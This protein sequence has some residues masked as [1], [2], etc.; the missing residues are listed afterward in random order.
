MLRDSLYPQPM[1]LQQMRAPGSLVSLG[2]FF[3]F[4]NAL[5]EGKGWAGDRESKTGT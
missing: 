3:F 1:L 5:M 2:I 4:F